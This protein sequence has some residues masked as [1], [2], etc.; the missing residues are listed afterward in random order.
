MCHND[1]FSFY[2]LESHFRVNHYSINVQC[3]P[4]KRDWSWFL[5]Y[6]YA[7]VR[8]RTKIQKQYAIDNYSIVK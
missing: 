7:N 4:I 1:N 8:I 2:I 6:Y 3:C 5:L